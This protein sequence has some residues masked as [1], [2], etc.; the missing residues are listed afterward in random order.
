MKLLSEYPLDLTRLLMSTKR[1]VLID[2]PRSR[3][4]SQKIQVIEN[5]SVI[6]I[7]DV[8]ESKNISTEEADKSP[9]ITNANKKNRINAEK[10][11]SATKIS[12]KVC[13]PTIY[14]KAI[15]NSIHSRRWKE[16]IEKHIQNL[17]N[18]YTWKY[19]Q[20]LLSWKTV[21]SKLV[22]KMKYY[23]DDSVA[24]YKTRLMA[25]GFLQIQR[26]DFNKRFLPTIRWESLQIFLAIS[27]LLRLIVK[28][29]D[30]I[31]AY[32]ESLLGDNN[33]PIFIKLLSE[34]EIFRSI[35]VGLVCRLLR[36]I[37]ELRQSRTL[38][39]QKI[40][41]FFTSLRF[42]PLNTDSSILIYQ[43]GGENIMMVNVYVDNFLFASKPQ[44]AL[45]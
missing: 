19:N 37:Y 38:W 34:M 4:Y 9:N 15:S 31:R 5:I 21:G 44:K 43:E 28:S 11:I 27:Y 3:G 25:Q 42:I 41:I 8:G 12:N 7:L 20:L 6:L 2:K 13:E 17:E 24:Y 36:S 32:F 30:I 14:E 1:K 22:F 33:L 35:R 10:V 39:N 16:A 29:V 45:N 26:I 23:L 18:H 40:I